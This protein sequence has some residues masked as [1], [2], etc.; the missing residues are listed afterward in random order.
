[1]TLW[2]SMLQ[3]PLTGFTGDVT[4]ASPVAIPGVNVARLAS[5]PLINVDGPV[6]A[7][8]VGG[9]QRAPGDVPIGPYV[10]TLSPITTPAGAPLAT[11]GLAATFN[12]GRAVA[13]LVMGR[14]GTKIEAWVDWPSVGGSFVVA[15]DSL[16]LN[17][18]ALDQA[19]GAAGSDWDVRMG[20]WATPVSSGAGAP[21]LPRYTQFVGT[22]NNGASSVE[23]F[24]PPFARRWRLTQTTVPSF[25]A[26]TNIQISYRRG[27][28][29]QALDQIIQSAARV[30]VDTTVPVDIPTWAT[31]IVLFNADA[32]PITFVRVVFE[33]DLA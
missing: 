18:L 26:T 24:I 33:L 20:A 22:I 2:G 6:M 7:P 17:A 19:T 15:C 11:S 1:M 9:G 30:F 25:S 14:G 27:G 31:A 8:H 10:I 21:Q 4:L 3:G 13:R 23:I 16:S 5:N 28:T 29:T 32:T 12:W